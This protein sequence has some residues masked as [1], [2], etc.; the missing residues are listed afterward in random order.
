[1]ILA[2]T[3]TPTSDAWVPLLPLLMVVVLGLMLG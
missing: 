2:Q 1:M 3:T